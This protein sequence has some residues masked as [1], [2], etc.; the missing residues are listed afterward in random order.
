[1]KTVFNAMKKKQKSQITRVKNDVKNFHLQKKHRYYVGARKRLFDKE[2]VLLSEIMKKESYIQFSLY[3]R[4]ILT[5]MIIYT[6]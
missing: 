6:I 4:D 2:Y 5:Y 3:N 1:M